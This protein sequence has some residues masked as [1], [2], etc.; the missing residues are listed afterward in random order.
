[1]KIALF[2]KVLH[3]FLCEASIWISK[4][5][6]Y[7]FSYFQKI[8]CKGLQKLYCLCYLVCICTPWCGTG[9]M[10]DCGRTIV[11]L[12]LLSGINPTLLSPP[13]TLTPT[14][15]ITKTTSQYPAQQ[16]HPALYLTA[17]PRNLSAL[18]N[19]RVL[20]IAPTLQMIVLDFIPCGL[21]AKQDSCCPKLKL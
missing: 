10:L 3:E 4:M 13:L 14:Q 8:I 16:Y 7:R 11:S 18:N 5:F 6:N 1:M 20:V 9:Q 21:G 12:S 19:K 15:Y 17:A 2:S